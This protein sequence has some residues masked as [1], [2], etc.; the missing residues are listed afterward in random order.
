MS[1]AASP[2]LSIVAIL[3]ESYFLESAW[4]LASAIAFAVDSPSNFLFQTV[5]SNIKVRDLLVALMV[6]VSHA[7][8][9]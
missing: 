5:D 4:S 6:S 9:V 7:S 8:D 1:E 3:V 2:Y